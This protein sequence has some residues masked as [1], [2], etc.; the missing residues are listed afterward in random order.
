MIGDTP[1]GEQL[2]LNAFESLHITNLNL[3]FRD[4]GVPLY[5]V[6]DFAFYADVTEAIFYT[7]AGKRF[8][9]PALT[10]AIGQDLDVAFAAFP[11][12]DRIKYITANSRENAIYLLNGPF[13]ECTQLVKH[14]GFDIKTN[15]SKLSPKVRPPN[16]V[17]YDRPK[18]MFA[19]IEEAMCDNAELKFR[20]RHIGASYGHP[21]QMLW[22]MVEGQEPIHVLTHYGN[23]GITSIISLIGERASD[24]SNDDILARRKHLNNL[25]VVG[26]D[27]PWEVDWTASMIDGETMHYR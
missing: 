5:S 16:I 24:L 19:V 1:A 10:H 27:M 3:D 15:I 26:M 7:E 23:T 17:V 6:D 25:F 14:L 21:F 20:F 11:K 9:T 18:D 12:G 22:I 2:F 13:R 8:I 4:T